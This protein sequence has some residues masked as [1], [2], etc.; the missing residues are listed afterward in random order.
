[1]QAIIL[2]AGMGKRLKEYTM[3]N[4]KCMVKINGIP[5]IE[6]SLRILDKKQLSQIILVTGY[7]GEKLTDYVTSLEIGTPILFIHNPV[8]DKTNNIYSLAL[9][10]EQLISEDTL[11]FESDIIFE[12]ALVDLL[13]DDKRETLALADKFASWMDGT[14]M[15]LDEDDSIKDFIPGK[16]LNFA[17]KGS[18]YKTV[19]IYKFSRHFST[20]TYVPFLEAY[21]KAMGNNEYYESVIKL[22]ALLE[23]KEIKAKRLEGQIWYEIDDIQDLDIAESIFAPTLK[24]RYQ[25]VAARYGGHWR[26]PKLLDFCYLVNPYFPP[27][28]LLDEM[29][30]NFETLISQYPSGMR[31]NSL[32]ASRSFGVRPEHILMGNGAAELIKMLMARLDG[33]TGFIRPTFEEYPNRYDPNS[34]VVF[35]PE[36]EDFRY[37]A[38]DLAEY[39]GEPEHEIRNLILINPDNPSGNYLAPDDLKKLIAWCRSKTIRLILDESFSDFVALEEAADRS[40]LFH[41]SAVEGLQASLINE[42]TLASYEELYLVKSIS[43]SYGVPGIRLGILASGNQDMVKGLKDDAAIWN[44]NS[45]GEFYMQISEKY[46]KDYQESLRK[47]AK[48]RARLYIGLSSIPFLRPLPTQA[49]YVMCQVVGGLTSERLACQL[50]QRDIL[51]KDLTSKLQNGY[52]YVRLAVRDEEDNEKLMSALKFIWENF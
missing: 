12:E 44:I 38:D 8:Y 34:S 19:N 46:K 4:T 32:L 45:F 16:Y 27:K 21:A 50:L 2:A 18:Y 23:T 10:K 3:E 33:P 52:Q 11:L 35:T 1:M 48:A 30:S 13:L 5:L 15:V 37:M 41:M 6:R 36:N 20:Y 39:F 43:K 29:K 22:I 31:V 24:D 40:P 14:C 47:M 9:A 26:Y 7:E 28:K 17:D 42:E 25:S 49:N 51:I